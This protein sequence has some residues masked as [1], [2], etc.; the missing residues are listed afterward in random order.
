M[1][2]NQ[3]MLVMKAHS[4]GYFPTSLVDG[5][6]CITI[7]SLDGGDVLITHSMVELVAFLNH[8]EN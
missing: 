8:L 5:S 2:I 3:I 4:Y 1:N 7:E 6:V